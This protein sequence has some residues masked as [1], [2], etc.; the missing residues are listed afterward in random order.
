MMLTI[1]RDEIIYLS[2]TYYFS[3]EGST[4]NGKLMTPL[5]Y[6][7]N[8]KFILWTYILWAGLKFK[9]YVQ[10][11]GMSHSF[12]W[13]KGEKRINLQKKKKIFFLLLC[14]PRLFLFLLFFH[15]L[16][17]FFIFLILCNK[18]TMHYIFLF[19]S[20]LWNIT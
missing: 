15:F 2:T 5:N 11:V 8:S 20:L 10:N 3:Q 13:K 1:V 16:L 12:A 19:F 9:N 14:L 4:P 18:N 6:N 17:L 7:Y